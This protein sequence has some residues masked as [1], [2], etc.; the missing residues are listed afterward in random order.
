MKAYEK[1]DPLA[2]LPTHRRLVE[3]ELV[4]AG[5]QHYRSAARRLAKMRKLAAG[6]S[7]PPRSMA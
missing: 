7:M 3:N 6:P 2:V 5:A 4:D 1:V